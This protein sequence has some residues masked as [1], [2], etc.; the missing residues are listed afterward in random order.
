MGENLSP[1]GQILCRFHLTSDLMHKGKAVIRKF[2]EFITENVHVNWIFFSLWLDSCM[3]NM[4][5]CGWVMSQCSIIII[6]HMEEI[7]LTNI[8]VQFSRFWI[9][10]LNAGMLMVGM[11][12]C[13]M[14]CRK[15][16]GIPSL[17]YQMKR[18]LWC[19]NWCSN[20]VSVVLVGSLL[21]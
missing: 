21:I 5:Y 14:F 4:E 7:S 20:W 1:F 2:S 18:S 12:S 16:H 8:L 3:S 9:H 17:F 15:V 19:R 10:Y 13:G 6:S 11:S